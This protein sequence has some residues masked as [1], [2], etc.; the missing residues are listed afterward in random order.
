MLWLAIFLFQGGVDLMAVPTGLFHGWYV[1][2]TSRFSLI[3]GR[4]LARHLGIY[5][6]TVA[7]YDT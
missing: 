3:Q 6:C 7:R 5:T 1:L 2:Q 4:D